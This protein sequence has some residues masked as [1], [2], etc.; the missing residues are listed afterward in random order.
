MHYPASSCL[1]PSRVSLG[2][3][4]HQLRLVSEPLMETLGAQAGIELAHEERLILPRNKNPTS[5]THQLD[6][7][8]ISSYS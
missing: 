4:R 8:S 1:K 2:C 6:V 3:Q 5:V 7:D